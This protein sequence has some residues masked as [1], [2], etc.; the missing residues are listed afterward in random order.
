MDLS[1]LFSLLSLC[2]IGYTTWTNAY[3]YNTFA[4][5]VASIGGNEGTI[6]I[7]SEQA[8]TDNLIIPTNLTLRFLHGGSLN[9]SVGKTVTINGHVEAP[10]VEI[11]EGAG[12][13]VL[14]TYPQDQAWWGNPQR[15]DFD[16]LTFQ[17][18]SGNQEITGA[19]IFSGQQYPI[20]FRNDGDLTVRWESYSNNQ[21]DNPTIKHYRG[22]GTRASELIVQDDDPCGE[23]TSYGFDGVTFIRVARIYMDVDGTPG[24]DDMP[25]RIDFEVTPD[26]EITPIVRMSLDNQ[27]LLT[28]NAYGSGDENFR[29]DGKGNENRDFIYRISGP[30]ADYN[31][32]ILQCEQTSG[33]EDFSDLFAF[34]YLG[35]FGI[36]TLAFGANM[37]SGLA[38][39]NAT[40]PTGNVA[41]CFQAYSAD[42]VAGNACLHTRTENGAVIKLYQCAKA[43]YNNWAAF[44]DV[45]DA[46]VAMGIF[47]AA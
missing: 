30:A 36:G 22:R 19:W 26:G 32:L 2:I 39:K 14:N 23:W 33:G 24:V 18:L 13:A 10:P 37:V 42:Q 34:N 6:M 44:G 12:T 7:A 35:N 46:L 1:I 8:V 9:I 45:V 15:S 38:M 27:G 21:Q 29:I 11:F 31:T 40:A 20:T 4:D 25:G 5:T 41:N 47:D 43:D 3:E 16:E 17:T 28:L